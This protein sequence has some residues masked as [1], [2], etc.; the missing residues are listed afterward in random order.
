MHCLSKKPNISICHRTTFYV[1]FNMGSFRKVKIQND[2]PKITQNQV[3]LLF[4]YQRVF[5][6]V[7]FIIF[8]NNS[9]DF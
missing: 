9:I 1:V 3:N 6:N 5:T 4:V 8:N 2:L 7:E